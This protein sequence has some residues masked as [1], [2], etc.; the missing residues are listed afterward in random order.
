MNLKV[1]NKQGSMKMIH[2]DVEAMGVGFYDAAVVAGKELALAFGMVPKELLADLSQQVT[3]RVVE[4]L[5]E[6]CEQTPEVMEWA[7]GRCP[8]QFESVRDFIRA[9]EKATISA[10]FAEA[11]RRGMTAW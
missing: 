6:A 9:T 1:K 7:M 8:E 3:R 4:L 5:A 2:V 11:K 10:A